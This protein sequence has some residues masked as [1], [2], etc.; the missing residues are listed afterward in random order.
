MA[1]HPALNA[2]TPA[3][4]VAAPQA[5]SPSRT[6]ALSEQQARDIAAWREH[7]AVAAELRTDATATVVA[8]AT[9]TADGNG[10]D[11]IPVGMDEVP[12][13]ADIGNH[14]V[15]L[16][17]PARAEIPVGGGGG[18]LAGVP[19]VTTAV[20]ARGQRTV[21]RSKA[22]Q[23]AMEREQAKRQELRMRGRDGS[24]RRQRWENGIVV[25]LCS[26]LGRD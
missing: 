8:A 21:P 3:S 5:S 7:A 19:V 9:A 17:E 25:M 4:I 26:R 23:I 16:H 24:R 11:N 13:D 20:T 6:P 18:Q 12:L 2:P 10:D 22:V 14:G 1:I 15:R